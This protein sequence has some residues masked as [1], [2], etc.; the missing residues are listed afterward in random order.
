MRFS[1]RQFLAAA[2][3]PQFSTTL[4]VVNVFATA[5]DQ[6]GRAV[7]D[8]ARADFRLEEE[9]RP[10]DIRYFSAEREAPLTVGLL[11]D[12]SGSTRFVQPAER[13][14][15]Q[16]FFQQAMRLKGDRGL[17][18]QFDA[19]VRV[20]AELTDMVSSLDRAASMAGETDR[21]AREIHPKGRRGRGTTLLFDA[22]VSVAQDVLA[23]EPGLKAVVLLSDG[24]DLGSA[25]TLAEA[26]EWAQRADLMVY[27]ILFGKP[28]HGPPPRF[29]LPPGPFPIPLP[30]PHPVPSRFPQHGSHV[31][32]ALAE[33]TG[34]RYFEIT[35]KLGLD[36]ILARIEEDLRHQYSLG[37]T[38]QN[39][40]AGA[41]FRRIR[42]TTRR[43]TV[44]VRTRT[45]YYAG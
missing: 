42:L 39:A 2:A 7:P 3:L 37:Y 20:L 22:V 18:V 30:A 10:Q 4:R 21:S 26:V 45:G 44:R 34:G 12:T 9:G 25:T 35:P 29:P 15:A 23:P 16:R 24:M 33:P 13:D 28:L 36:A 40:A 5:T 1:R 14:V 6:H 38:P 17:V 27:S 19:R 32:R 11:I 31:L 43:R 41:G 8:L